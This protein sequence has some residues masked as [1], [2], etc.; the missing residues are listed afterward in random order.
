M[1]M[2]SSARDRTLIK[3][4]LLVALNSIFDPD[5][6]FEEI[7]VQYH[8]VERVW[9]I[10]LSEQGQDAFPLSGSGSG[11]KT[12]IL[13]LLNLLVRPDFE[14]KAIENYIFS[15]EE[16][17]N[18]LHPALQRNLFR[19]LM[20]FSLEHKCHIIMTAH[21]HVA[22][23]YFHGNENAQIVHVKKQGSEVV[24]CLLKD[25]GHGYSVLDDLGAKASDILQANGII[26]VEGPSDRVFLNKFIEIWGDGQF[27]EGQHFQYI[28]YGGS[29]LNNISIDVPDDVLQEAVSALRIN[30]NFIFV[31]DSD[32][33][34][35]K[36]PLKGRVTKLVDK[37]VDS[38]GYVWVTKC[39]EIENYIP[40][41]AIGKV[42]ERAGIP[43]I[44][45]YEY[46]QDYLN[47]HKI[48]KAKEYRDKHQK[49][50]E[51]AR[52]FTRENLSFRKDLGIEM[53]KIIDKIRGW[54]S[55]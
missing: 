27:F 30:R 34:N 46:I 36:G 13:C 44:G 17:E 18:N 24:G 8:D 35:A 49:A 41:E 43:P 9:E 26:W 3:S 15:L 16:L 37:I 32:R 33:K 19:F 31:C 52:H 51:F 45:T 25:Y 6:T 42:Y 48:S 53:E 21:S 12:V 10:Y 23:D 22:I 14:S 5:I 40:P 50:V 38:S 55:R 54:N 11:L 1:Y 47:A 28:F 7:L 20:D 39:K 29:I 2:N 4:R